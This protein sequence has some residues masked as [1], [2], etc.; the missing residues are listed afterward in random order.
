M[1]WMLTGDEFGADEA[2][3]MGIVQE[4]TEDGAGAVARAREIAQT[5]AE[6]AAPLAIRALMASAHRKPSRDEGDAEAI[7]HLNPEITRL[8]A[9]ADAAEGVQSFVERR[10]AN[11]VGR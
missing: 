4:I 9:T 5:I 7:K 11:F 10:K 8:F 3:R 2:Y 6:E 1:R